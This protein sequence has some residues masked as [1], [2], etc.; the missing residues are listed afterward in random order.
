MK[1]ESSIQLFSSNKDE[2]TFNIPSAFVS[3]VILSDEIQYAT[4]KIILQNLTDSYIL[5]NIKTNHKNDYCVTPKTFIIDPNKET[6]TEIKFNLKQ[7]ST[8]LSNHKFKFCGYKID[9]KNDIK[10]GAKAL[11]NEIE[12]KE[13]EQSS[14]KISVQ[15]KLIDEEGNIKNIDNKNEQQ[16]EDSIYL[17]QCKSSIT[18]S[19]FNKSQE[20]NLNQNISNDNTKAFND[21]D[22]DVLKVE[23]ANLKQQLENTIEEYN[24]L[25]NKVEMESNRVANDVKTVTEFVNTNEKRISSKIVL[26]CCVIAFLLG[27]FL[28]S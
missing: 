6:E 17:S 14:L 13:V 3:Q 11:L 16:I 12:K 7:S 27:M 19:Q 23:Y 15:F 26:I 1:E 18:D 24:N 25:K 8:D 4:D 28:S 5:I 2:L 22:I 21:K 20:Y 10:K 9:D